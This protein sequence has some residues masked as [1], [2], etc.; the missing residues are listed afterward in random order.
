MLVVEVAWRCMEA[1]WWA[2]IAGPVVAV[3]TE[4]AEVMVASRAMEA[5]EGEVEALAEAKEVRVR[6]V[7][8]TEVAVKA[9]AESERAREVAVKVRVGEARVR[10]ESESPHPALRGARQRRSQSGRRALA[11]LC[12]RGTSCNRPQWLGLAR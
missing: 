2:M 9:K 10:E 8:V 1:V 5:Q 4:E 3:A 7:E 6:G 12:Q 11:R